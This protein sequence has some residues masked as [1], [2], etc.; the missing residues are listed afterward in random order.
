MNL[1]LH[2]TDDYP[3]FLIL[4]YRENGYTVNVIENIEKNDVVSIDSI[5]VSKDNE[6]FEEF[7]QC[8]YNFNTEMNETT[9]NYVN[10]YSDTPATKFV[11]DYLWNEYCKSI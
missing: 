10:G 8:E 1:F 7:L 4:N 3:N 2:Q 5:S 11:L 6:L 9:T